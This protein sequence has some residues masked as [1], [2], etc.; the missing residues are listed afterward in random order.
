MQALRARGA[1]VTALD[2]R[3]IVDVPGDAV[4]ARIPFDQ[5]PGHAVYHCHIRD[6]EAPGMTGVIDAT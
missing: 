5:F 4:T 2:V 1:D 6:H 3:D